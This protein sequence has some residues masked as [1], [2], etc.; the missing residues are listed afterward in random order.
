MMVIT[1]FHSFVTPCGPK[2][3]EPSSM[4]SV[5]VKTTVATYLGPVTWTGRRQTVTGGIWWWPTSTKLV[6]KRVTYSLSW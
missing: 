1:T 6:F 3:S 2:H 5:N 4:V